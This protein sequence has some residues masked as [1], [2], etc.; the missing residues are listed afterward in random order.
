MAIYCNTLEGNMQYN[1]DPYCFTPT[2]WV[3]VLSII[4]Y[5]CTC[6]CVYMFTFICIFTSVHV[7]QSPYVYLISFHSLQAYL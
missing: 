4:V 3:S 2:V 7:L 1:D 6:I 5:V